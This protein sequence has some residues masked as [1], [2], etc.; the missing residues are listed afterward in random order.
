MAVQELI[1][2]DEWMPVSALFATQ[3]LISISAPYQEAP[4]PVHQSHTAIKLEH[5]QGPSGT[6]R[7]S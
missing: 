3:Y 2:E 4:L 1:E 7:R 6:S 5:H